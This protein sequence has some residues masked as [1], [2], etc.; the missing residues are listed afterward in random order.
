MDKQNIS[1]VDDDEAVRASL[2]VL[3]E[4]AGYD[5]VAFASA[6]A[7]L[8]E[9]TFRG[10]CLI[11]DVRMPDMDG[12]ALQQE[13]QRRGV[14]RPVIFVTGYGDVPLAVRAMKAGAID[15]IE[16]PFDDAVLLESVAKALDATAH[17]RQTEEALQSIAL[18]TPREREVLEQLAYGRSN[19]VAGHALNISPRTVEIHRARVMSKLKARGL[20]D[21]VRTALAASSQQRLQ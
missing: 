21:L 15:F 16:K 13:L 1:V 12:L 20:S 7:L 2:Q 3:L 14:R 5:V 8:A 9:P 11:S 19:K 17:A 10:A 4:S 6:A 18:L